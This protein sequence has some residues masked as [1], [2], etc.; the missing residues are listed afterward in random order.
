[1]MLLSNIPSTSHSKFLESDLSLV[2]R[3]IYSSKMV[4]SEA[5]KVVIP[6]TI[7]PAPHNM[8]QFEFMAP[9]DNEPIL[10]SSFSF[11]LH[12]ITEEEQKAKKE[13][14]K[15]A[16]KQGGKVEEKKEEVVVPITPEAAEEWEMLNNQNT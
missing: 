10:L 2:V 14:K 4:T 9:Q 6:I 1:M 12:K 5:P 13:A 8:V 11:N 16:K 3:A 7:L 15:L